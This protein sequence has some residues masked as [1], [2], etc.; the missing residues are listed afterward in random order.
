MNSY[1][2]FYLFFLDDF[3]D[4]IFELFIGGKNESLSLIL[5]VSL[6]VFRSFWDLFL[7]KASS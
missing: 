4:R 5:E 3:S 6:D 1:K 2:L 7:L